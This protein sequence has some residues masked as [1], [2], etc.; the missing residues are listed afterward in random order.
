MFLVYGKHNGLRTSNGVIE[1]KKGL[2][3]QAT[4]TVFVKTPENQPVEGAAVSLTYG[5]TVLN[6]TTDNTGNCV[7]PNIDC[8]GWTGSVSGTS[9]FVPQKFLQ[10]VNCTQIVYVGCGVSAS[11]SV[12]MMDNFGNVVPNAV[13]MACGSN[14]IY[15]FAD[16][17]GFEDVPP[18]MYTIQGYA[19]GYVSTT[20]FGCVVNPGD[21][22]D[23]FSVTM[24]KIPSRTG[25]AIFTVKDNINRDPIPGA[26]VEIIG[27]EGSVSLE[28]D[29]NGQ[30]S[31]SNLTVGVNGFFWPYTIQVSKPGYWPVAGELGCSDIGNGGQT[32]YLLELNYTPPPPP[33]PPGP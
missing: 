32:D 31:V 25:R 12:T 5:T 16:G 2:N 4:L 6:G 3:V 27:P 15:I 18:S 22:G 11:F 33:P 8:C 14:E 20:E 23:N 19:Y 9:F 13:A 28:T 21:Y 1:L 24:I 30:V 26:T 17:G 10:G 7:F 29:I